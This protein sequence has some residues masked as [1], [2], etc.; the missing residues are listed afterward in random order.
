MQKIIINLCLACCLLVAIGNGCRNTQL[1]NSELGSAKILELGKQY[2]EKGEY[3]QSREYFY[4]LVNFY[5]GTGEAAEAQYLLSKSYFDQEKYE[6]ALVEFEVVIDRYPNSEFVDDA[7]YFIGWCY[8]NESPD[9]QRDL[10]LVQSAIDSFQTVILDYELSNRMEEAK[11]GLLSARNKLAKKEF[12]IA[13]FYLSSKKYPAASIYFQDIAENYS[14]TLYVG[15]SIYY[16]GECKQKDG[17]AEGA[18]GYYQQYI[19]SY[20]Y[21]DWV[22]N[23]QDH[24]AEISKNP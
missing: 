21:G 10:S 14:D 4:H 9:L 8:L 5:P 7:Y 18:K 11:Q 3:K 1:L 16:L 24:L 23:A 22:K 20:P 2:L 6:N 15:D 19:S 13:K 12:Y 17:D